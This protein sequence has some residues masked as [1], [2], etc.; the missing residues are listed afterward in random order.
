MPKPQG[1]RGEIRFLT[2]L[3][4][5]FSRCFLVSTGVGQRVF[6]DFAL[7]PKGRRGKL[8]FLMVLEGFCGALSQA[9]AWDSVF[10]ADFV[11]EPKARRVNV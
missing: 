5:F 6:V 9:L 2:V 1:R 4:V 8:R 3:K 10:L 11:L 7:E